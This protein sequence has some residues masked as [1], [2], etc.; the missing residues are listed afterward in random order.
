MNTRTL[1]ARSVILV[2]DGA[3]LGFAKFVDGPKRLL[4][5]RLHPHDVVVSGIRDRCP[6]LTVERTE[7]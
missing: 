2:G 3:T 5:A 1:F 7:L 6:T 4:D